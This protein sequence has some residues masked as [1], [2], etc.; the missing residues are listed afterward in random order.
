MRLE[1]YLAQVERWPREGRHIAVASLDVRLQWD[2]D[3]H[4]SGAPVERRAVQLGLRG[5]A[6]RR[7]AREAIAAVEDVT[8]L[9]I[10]QRAHVERRDWAAL[11]TPRE[12]VYPVDPALAANLGMS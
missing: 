6:L 4:P 7:Y 3:H 8:D 1:S 11:V 5:A 12:E 9:V 2:P 10:E